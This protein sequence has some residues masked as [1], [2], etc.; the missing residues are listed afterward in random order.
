MLLD[1]LRRQ[2]WG[3]LAGRPWK[4]LRAVLTGLAS[5]LPY[6]SAQGDTTIEQVA[7]AA[8]YGLRWTRQCLTD[9]EDFGL[10]EWVRG[11]VRY[12]R[13]VPSRFRI[14][15]RMLVEL[16]QAAREKRTAEMVAWAARTR[17]RLERIRTIRLV[18]GRRKTRPEAAPRRLVQSKTAG[19]CGNAHAAVAASPSPKRGDRTGL[20]SPVENT[21]PP[22]TSTRRQPSSLPEGLTG[23]ALARAVLAGLGRR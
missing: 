2:G 14:D 19:S 23:P 16:L 4:G 11:G 9:L 7:S 15:K 12:G 3:P 21:P 5:R 20:R 13:P 17:T 1:T 8:G 6:G 22:R 18:K 10:I